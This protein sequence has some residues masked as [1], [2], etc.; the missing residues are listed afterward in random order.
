VKVGRCIRGGQRAQ[1]RATSAPCSAVAGINAGYSLALDMPAGEAS[2]M[3]CGGCKLDHVSGWWT[4]QR[5][6]Y[7]KGERGVPPR[8]CDR[9]HCQTPWIYGNKKKYAPFQGTRIGELEFANRVV[10]RVWIKCPVMRIVWIF[11]ICR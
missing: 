2:N 3:R 5:H 1:R 7:C 10:C 4:E 11:K 6:I 8:K 9:A